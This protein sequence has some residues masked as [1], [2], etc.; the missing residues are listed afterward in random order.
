MKVGQTVFNEWHGIRRYGVV[1]TLE[2]KD[3]GQIVPWTYARV[4]WF[5][6]EPYLA[7][8]KNTN[9][10]RNDG[11]DCSKTEYRVDKLK[12]INLDKEVNTMLKIQ[13]YVK[14]EEVK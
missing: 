3:E 12:T 6:D 4:K 1:M 13:E 10:L 8:T 14:L 9:K 11:S 5:D 2:E 7:V